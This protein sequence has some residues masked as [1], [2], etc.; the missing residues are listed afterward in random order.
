MI[1]TNKQLGIFENN[2]LKDLEEFDNNSKLE[3]LEK[4]EVSK[5][6]EL[7]THEKK[8]AE[9][10]E[11]LRTKPEIYSR[12]VGYIRPTNQWNDGK[13]AE[14]KDRKVFIVAPPQIKTIVQI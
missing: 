2:E 8:S 14:F 11:K 12:V 4:T 13:Q 3:G 6:D 9:E 1:E 5:D 7:G 10:I